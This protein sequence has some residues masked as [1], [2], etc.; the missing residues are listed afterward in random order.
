MKSKYYEAELAYLREGG[1]EFARAYPNAA[2]LLAERSSDPDVERLLEGFA[3]LAGRVRERVD[4]ALPEIAHHYAAILV[5]HLTQYIPPMSTVQFRP[6][7]G[8]RTPVDLPR[9]APVAGLAPDGTRCQFQTTTPLTLLPLALDDVRHERPGTRI[10]K[11]ILALRMAPPQVAAVGKASIRL[12]F[13][14]ETAF[15]TTLRSWFLHY[16]TAVEVVAE[17]EVVGRLDP[18]AIKPVGH[19]V[20]ERLLPQS[21]L[22]HDAFTIAAEF[23][24]YPEKFAFVDLPPIGGAARARCELHFSFDKAPKLSRPP[25]DGDVRLHCA[26]VINL[27]KTTGEPVRFDPLRPEGLVQASGLTPAQAEVWGVTE[28]VG[29]AQS[30]RRTYPPF[31]SFQAEVG[32]DSRFFATRRAPS[33]AATGT[34]LFVSLV[35]PRDAEIIADPEVL[36]MSLLCSNRAAACA[37]KIGQLNQHVR[38][39]ATSVPFTNI[40]PVTPPLYPHDDGELVWRLAAHIGLSRR[41]LQDATNLRRLLETYNLAARFSPRLG[42]LNSPWIA[43]IREVQVTKSVRVYRGAPV[44]GTRSTV[45]LDGANLS[46]PGEAYVF[47]EILNE[48][49]ARRVLI[50]SFNQLEIRISPS[51]ERCTW[52][53]RNGSFA[54][55]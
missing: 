14:G 55:I 46:S 31:A 5:P 10:D 42:R 16:C 9:G 39:S 51:G 52:E 7:K 40:S 35:A 29:L 54:L 19:A 13:H 1:K 34:D 18:S 43:A 25:V 47:G 12:F 27:F 17:G 45:I 44:T 26:P 4:D 33:S 8:L 11:V 6:D 2:G 21:P 24:S 50:N 32:A 3:F 38:G 28:V 37:L 22:E 20:E 53:P 36:S 15:W 41:G 49:F 23:F 48:V 30:S